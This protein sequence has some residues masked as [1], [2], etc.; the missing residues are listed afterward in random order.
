MSQTRGPP[1][2]RGILLQKKDH[3]PHDVVLNILVRL[4][5]KS[6]LRFRCVSKTWDSSITTPSFISTH[7][8]LN[9]NNNNNNNSLDCLITPTISLGFPFIIT[10]P[11]LIGGYDHAFNRISKYSAFPRIHLASS[12]NGLV[13][14]Y[15]FTKAST[16]ANS[17]YLWNPA[18]ENLRGC[19]LF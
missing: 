12:C 15:R 3:L 18:L 17:I 9:L 10:I 14:L 4:P 13:C 16:N 5:V 19:L 6:V 7:L 2:P 8:N 11:S 1:H